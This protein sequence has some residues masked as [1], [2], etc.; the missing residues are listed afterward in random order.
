VPSLRWGVI[1]TGWIAERF[2]Q[3][4]Q[5]HTTQRV[6]AVGSRTAGTAARFAAAAGIPVAHG[7]HEALVADPD[8][9]VVYVATQHQA[10]RA[11]A[12]LAI[13]A[14]KHVLV[15]KPLGLNAVEAQEVFAAAA[16]ADVLCLEAM[17]TAFLPRFDVVR[18]VL[19][20]G[21]L[22]DVRTVLA[23]HG[24]R[25]D[26]PHRILE[27]AQAGGALLDL[28][29]YLTALATWTLG[30]ATHV[31]ATGEATA[32]GVVGQAA[33]VLTHA[34]GGRSVLHTT[35]LGRTPM[36]AA[37][38]GTAAT[39][40]LPGPFFM[41]GDVVLTSADGTRTVTWTDP[42][43]I[44]H[45]GLY[46]SAVEVAQRL[47][48]ARL[49][50]PLLPAADVVAALQA[51]DEVTRQIAMTPHDAS[52]DASDDASADASDDALNGKGTTP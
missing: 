43:P 1:G 24:E 39:L 41:P 22:G 13:G 19:D 7:S 47:D 34:G 32:S 25:F 31:Y 11:G 48:E 44:R 52:A 27:P 18:Q 51:L 37:L 40:T 20:A 3:S 8:V 17:W 12:L 36:S 26:P 42:Q 2:V 50:S 21:I 9:D 29:S 14:G 38:V 6:V 33:M 5:A 35:I 4:L 10:H 23:D 46:H 16:A 28:G 45:G 30:P 49:D 15:E